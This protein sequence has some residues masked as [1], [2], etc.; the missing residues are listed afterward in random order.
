MIFM[1]IVGKNVVRIRLNS[2]LCITIYKIQKLLVVK[3]TSL[4]S[5]TDLHSNQATS[6][7]SEL[8][9]PDVVFSEVKR[10]LILEHIWH[11]GHKIL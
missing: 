11:Q 2:L 5:V 10:P 7:S 9:V 3:A 6:L 8:C 1:R 4:Q